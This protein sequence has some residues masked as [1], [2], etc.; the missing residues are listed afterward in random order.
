MDNVEE[1]YYSGVRKKAKSIFSTVTR[2]PGLFK[3]YP[4]IEYNPQTSFARVDSGM[5][6]AFRMECANKNIAILIYP[7]SFKL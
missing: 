1:D 3:N 4:G 2:Y 6:S 5:E 7:P